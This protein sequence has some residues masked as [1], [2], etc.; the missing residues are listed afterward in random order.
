MYTEMFLQALSGSINL[1]LLASNHQ[2][3]LDDKKTLD[4][5]F[6]VLKK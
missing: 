6:R 4:D 5:K 2:K 3:L 1:D